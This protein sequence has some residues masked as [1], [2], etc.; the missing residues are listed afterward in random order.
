MPIAADVTTL[1]LVALEAIK[2]AKTSW[3]GALPRFD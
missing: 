1:K 2:K 3:V